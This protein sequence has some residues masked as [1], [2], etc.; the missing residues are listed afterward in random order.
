MDGLAVV[1]QQGLHAWIV[2]VATA[3]PS[4]PR[5]EATA[6]PPT[7]PLAPTINR[8]SLVHLCT[9]MLVA[10]LSSPIPKELR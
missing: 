1:R 10:T 6:P 5:T 9:D 2:L 8:S 7:G 4:S 3:P